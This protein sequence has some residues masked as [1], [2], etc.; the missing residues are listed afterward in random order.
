MD[1]IAW[2]VARSHFSCSP[3][4]ECLRLHVPMVHVG[5]STER[6]RPR[7]C[8]QSESRGSPGVST[9][10]SEPFCGV[11][12][13]PLGG[14]PAS[15]SPSCPHWYPAPR[16]T[17]DRLSSRPVSPPQPLTVLPELPFQINRCTHPCSGRLASP[18]TP[19]RTCSEVHSEMSFV[20][21]G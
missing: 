9:P 11:F 4:A 3:M 7:E 10:T 18:C 1:R 16:P 2:E 8:P 12:L 14:C 21:R 19:P 15:L 17:L 20:A 13:Q 6:S 5:D